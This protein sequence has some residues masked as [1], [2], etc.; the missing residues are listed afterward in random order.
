[1]VWE[2]SYN[3]LGH[4]FIFTCKQKESSLEDRS[5]GWLHMYLSHAYTAPAFNILAL[6]FLGLEKTCFFWKRKLVKYPY[7]WQVLHWYLFAGHW[8]L[9]TC[10]ESHFWHLFVL[11]NILW[12]KTF[13]L[14]V[15]R[16]W[17]FVTCIILVTRWSRFHIWLLL[18]MFACWEICVLVLHQIDLCC[19]G[20]TCHLLDVSG[21]HLWTLTFLSKLTDLTWW[22]LVQIYIAVIYG[23]RHKIFILKKEAKIPLWRILAVSGGY[24]ARATWVW[25]ELY[26]SSTDLFPCL[27]LVRRSN[28]AL[29]SF[30]WGLQNSLN[31]L[32][33]CIKGKLLS[34]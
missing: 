31:F 28:W 19:L 34:R 17:L 29:T 33:I 7:L 6:G 11:V 21:S 3:Q 27:K 26:H 32:Q 30:D 8:N 10:K 9:S 24:L 25:T 23:F 12:I 13:L 2:F 15:W 22:E 16:Y 4:A 14:V 20:I 18:L 1:M 5:S